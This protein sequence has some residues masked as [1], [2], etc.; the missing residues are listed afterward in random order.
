MREG[1][2]ARVKHRAEDAAEER[3]LDVLLPRPS[4]FQQEADDSASGT[5]QKFRK[6][7]PRASSTTRKSRSMCRRPRWVSR[8][9]RLRV[10]RK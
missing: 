1:E 10:W 2:L 6:M 5:R 4:D 9:W 7:L 3:I 8:S